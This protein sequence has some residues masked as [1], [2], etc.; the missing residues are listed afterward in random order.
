[1]C[2][3]RTLGSAHTLSTNTPS[4]QNAL[5]ENTVV[6]ALAGQLQR[7]RGGS[8]LLH[9][10]F[11][12]KHTRNERLFLKSLAAKVA[13]FLLPHSKEPRP[14]S[15]RYMLIGFVPF[16]LLRGPARTLKLMAQPI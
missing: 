7:K 5:P 16:L 3:E 4:T 10:H 15:A 12:K 13:H 11:Q 14:I 2:A 1:M 6:E 9:Q 8:Q